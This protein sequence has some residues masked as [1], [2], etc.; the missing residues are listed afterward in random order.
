MR[1]QRILSDHPIRS[2]LWT[3]VESTGLLKPGMVVPSKHR[4][5]RDLSFGL[6]PLT[7][8]LTKFASATP[9][10]STLTKT[11]D[12]KSFNINT[13]K[14]GGG[15][16]RFLRGPIGSARALAGCAPSNSSA[17]SAVRHF[18]YARSREPG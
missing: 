5:S 1:Q 4:E 3:P 11:K 2:G 12:L 16:D 9:L 18:C 14:K 7:S 17:S 10:T 6:S 15:G 8:T 13:Y